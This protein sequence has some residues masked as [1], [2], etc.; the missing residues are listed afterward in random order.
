MRRT[1]STSLALA[2]LLALTPLAACSGD[3]PTD[4]RAADR[5]GDPGAATGIPPRYLEGLAAGLERYPDVGTTGLGE[6]QWR[7]PVEE[8]VEVDGKEHDESR[9]TSVRQPSEG[10]YELDCSFYPPLSV[11]LAVFRAEDAEGYEQLV[12][13]TA[14]VEQQGNE[15]TEQQV[16]VG[17]RE[18]TVVRFEYPTNPAAGVAFE[19]HHLDPEQRARV[20]LTVNDSDERSA[21]YDGAAAAADLAAILSR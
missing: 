15:Q 18:F 6:L 21:G 19:A 7:C 10:I 2:L 11:E 3:E 9:S 17:S 16:T 4:D 13:A 5:S 12:A 14:A 20:T 8:A 1:S